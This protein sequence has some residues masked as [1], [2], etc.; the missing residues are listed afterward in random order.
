MYFFIRNLYRKVFG[1]KFR[2]FIGY[3]I[4]SL[5]SFI[6]YLINLCRNLKYLFIKPSRFKLF[7]KSFIKQFFV[8]LFTKKLRV[9]LL[10]FRSDNLDELFNSIHVLLESKEVL[11]KPVKIKN[12][13]INNNN[14]Y[15]MNQYSYKENQIKLLKI[16]EAFIYGDIDLII[17]KN[18]C[19]ISDYFDPNYL[20]SADE[21]RNNISFSKDLKFIDLV[22]KNNY[23]KSR[24]LFQIENG[25]YIK[26]GCGKNFFHWVTEIAPKISIYF[27]YVDKE[28]KILV[29]DGLHKNIMRLIEILNIKKYEIINLEKDKKYL[30]K[31][32]YIITGISNIPF[33]FRYKYKTNNFFKDS[34]LEVK[35]NSEAFLLLNENL[36]KFFNKPN[37]NGPKK[38]YFKRISD[39]NRQIKNIDEIE[40][41]LRSMNFEFIDPLNYTI[42]TLAEKLNNVDILIMQGGSAFANIILLRKPAKIFLMVI[43]HSKP[44]YHTFSN[45]ASVLGHSS[46][47]LFGESNLNENN[48][49]INNTHHDFKINLDLLKDLSD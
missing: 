19:F 31:N 25:L 37:I 2:Y 49:K 33:E 16:K 44:L 23:L 20:I 35:Y 18:L 48:F 47:F 39:L 22:I 41:K 24:N 10:N 34:N 14:S 7:I 4:Y 21:Y 26:S 42:D 43:D 1:Y 46:F 30:I 36:N 40:K 12:Y 13:Q 28:L 29:N 3:T 6:R 15:L 11:I 27:K 5:R 45:L 8:K 38:V 32:L 17:K 9:K